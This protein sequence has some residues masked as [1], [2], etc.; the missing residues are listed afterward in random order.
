LQ[1]AGRIYTRAAAA[2][3]AAV[4]SRSNITTKYFIICPTK[5]FG[6]K[7]CRRAAVVA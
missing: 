6:G 4:R 1:S 2:A 7:L 5:N 3:A